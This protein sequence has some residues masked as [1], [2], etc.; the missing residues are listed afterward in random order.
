MSS[1]VGEKPSRSSHRPAPFSCVD[2]IAYNSPNCETPTSTNLWA[3]RCMNT[4]NRLSVSVISRLRNGRPFTPMTIAAA[5]I[6]WPSSSAT[7]PAK[8]GTM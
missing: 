6:S 2:S 7:T 5:P 1:F 8:R 3:V 4:G